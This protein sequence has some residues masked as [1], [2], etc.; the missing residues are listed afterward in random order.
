MN[1]NDQN[2]KK[3][4]TTETKY[5]EYNFYYD[6]VLTENVFSVEEKYFSP[7]T[8]LPLIIPEPDQTMKLTT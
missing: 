1:L 4:D 8:I 6:G 2:P 5:Q 7:T 3:N